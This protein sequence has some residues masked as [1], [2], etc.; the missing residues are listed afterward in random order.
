[1]F[2]I[3]FCRIALVSQLLSRTMPTTTCSTFSLLCPISE[4]IGSW[5]SGACSLN[6]P[7]VDLQLP[8]GTKLITKTLNCDF[9]LKTKVLT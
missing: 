4:T 2:F 8:G 9:R 3:F 7:D 1:M 5:G 6:T